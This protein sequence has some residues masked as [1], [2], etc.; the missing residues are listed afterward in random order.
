M[1]I[2]LSNKAY[3][4]TGHDAISYD[5]AAGILSENIGRNTSYASISEDD[6]RKAIIDLWMSDRHTNILLELLKLSREGHLSN[7]SQR[8]ND[9]VKAILI[10]ITYLSLFFYQP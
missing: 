2:S 9:N 6:A 1:I 10:G 4:L 8:R 7:I 5:G 3:A